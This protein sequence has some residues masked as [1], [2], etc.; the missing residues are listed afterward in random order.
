MLTFLT[1]KLSQIGAIILAL[2]VLVVSAFRSGKEQQKTVEKY[3]DLE[4]YKETRDRIDETVVNTDVSDALDRLSKNGQ[5][6]D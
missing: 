6:R 3:K 2:V 5:L 4:E 1:N